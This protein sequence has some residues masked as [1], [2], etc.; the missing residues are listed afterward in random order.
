MKRT[1][2]LIALC[3]FAFNSFAQTPSDYSFQRTYNVSVPA[4]MS[5]STNDGFI[6]AFGKNDNEIKVYFVVKKNNRVV[7]ID[8]DELKEHV[9]I[10]IS[11]SADKLEIIVKRK[12]SNWIK[13][14]KNQYYVSLHILAPSRTACTLKTSDGDI[15]MIGFVGDQSCKTSDGDILVE[16]IQGDLYVRTSDGD[17]DISDVE[18]SVESSTSDGDIKAVKI[19]GKSTF[20]TSDGKIY[21]SDLNEDI[22]ATTSDGDIILEN[23]TGMN[24]LRTSDGNIIFENMQGSLTAQTSDG[25][26]RGELNSLTN[27]LYL[28]TSDGDISVSIPQ[29]LGMDV[30]LKG[31]DINT[32]LDDFSGKTSDHLIEGTIRGGGVEVELI[33]SDGDI[34]LNYN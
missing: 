27:K 4:K 6:K 34:N 10:E 12:E 8:L 32:E 16:E 3:A 24:S 29:G 20:K 30:R 28:K 1:I 23:A 33:T 18:G 11:S 21:A 17:I 9:N 15:E 5:I 2:T 19:K 31:E 26:I 25:D 14:W 13:D 7:D 22:H